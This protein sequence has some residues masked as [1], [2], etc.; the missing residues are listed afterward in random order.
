MTDYNLTISIGRN[1]P[2]GGQ[3]PLHVWDQFIDETDDVAARFIEEGS[4]A[5]VVQRGKLRG[6]WDG[7]DEE[8]YTVTVAGLD[9]SRVIY[10]S[11]KHLLPFGDR[12]AT[13]AEWIEFLV[14]GL[15]T[16]YQQEAI[17]VTWARPELIGPR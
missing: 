17:A 15:A 6:F 8:C 7:E 4:G 12:D 2:G 10:G 13:V 5:Q 1:L 3:L 14:G 16:F 11:A 9:P